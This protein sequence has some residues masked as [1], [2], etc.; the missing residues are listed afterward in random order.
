MASKEVGLSS[1]IWPSRKA[2]KGSSKNIYQ[3]LDLL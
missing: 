2:T 1:G 3:M